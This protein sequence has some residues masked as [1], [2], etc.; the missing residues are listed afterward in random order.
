MNYA[1]DVIYESF[2]LNSS[3]SRNSRSFPV[4]PF[5]AMIVLMIAVHDYPVATTVG[6]L[7][8]MVIADIML[9][10]ESFDMECKLERC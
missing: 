10:L 5:A 9:K 7:P 6:K 8:N 3:N 2:L 1:N 4:H